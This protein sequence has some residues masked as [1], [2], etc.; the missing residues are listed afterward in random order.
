MTRKRRPQLDAGAVAGARQQ[1]AVVDRRLHHRRAR[2]CPA[3]SRADQ[4]GNVGA[5][6]PAVSRGEARATDAVGCPRFPAIHQGRRAPVSG[7]H[8]FHHDP[9]RRLAVHSRRAG[10]W[11][12]PSP[13]PRWWACTSGNFT[14][15]AREPDLVR[16][17]WNGSACCAPA[18][19]SRRIARPT[20]RICSRTAI[21]EFLVLNPSFPHSIRFSADA[22]ETAAEGDRRGRSRADDPRAS[23]A[24]R[25]ACRRRSRFGQIDEIMAAVC[26]SYLDT[27]LRQCGQ[28]HS[29]LHQTYIAYPI[30]AAL[31][32]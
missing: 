17:H 27:V 5:V 29:A 30:E 11:S 21:A 12:G 15:T 13:C 9:R 23:N 2:E 4:L 26:T 20:R 31:G 22:L 19:R 3:G 10:T 16:V 28:V 25:A 6:E 18:P 1:P 32:A 8:G 14:P 24:S 7:H